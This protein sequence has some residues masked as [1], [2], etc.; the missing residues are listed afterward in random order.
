MQNKN[1]AGEQTHFWFVFITDLGFPIRP[2]YDDAENYF[3]PAFRYSV[4][5][6]SR[7]EANAFY[8]DLLK[9]IDTLNIFRGVCKEYL[10][11]EKT[12]F[13]KKELDFYDHEVKTDKYIGEITLPCQD[14]GVEQ[15]LNFSKESLNKILNIIY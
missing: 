5:F 8:V 2:K 11:S 6:N 13:I 14:T 15:F 10:E 1:N 4:K 3:N 7:G 12:I 9:Y